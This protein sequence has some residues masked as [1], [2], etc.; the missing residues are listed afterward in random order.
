METELSLSKHLGKLS[1][2]K[3]K[4]MLTA[5]QLDCQPE[6]GCGHP[7]V[8]Q[9]SSLPSACSWQRTPGGQGGHR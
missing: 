4:D 3:E 2:R 8:S 6:Q 9:G 7:E 1:P 5:C